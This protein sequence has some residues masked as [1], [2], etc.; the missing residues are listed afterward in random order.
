[1]KYKLKKDMPGVKKGTVF[2]PHDSSQYSPEGKYFPL[3]PNESVENNSDWFDS[4]T[5]NEFTSKDMV[6]F[7]RWYNK[8]RSNKPVKE[9]SRTWV[10]RWIELNKPE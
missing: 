1:M 10:T 8:K 7:V 6:A 2:V 3:L 4:Y 9:I 5:E